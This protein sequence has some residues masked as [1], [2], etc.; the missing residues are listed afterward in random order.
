VRSLRLSLCFSS[1]AGSSSRVRDLRHERHERV[2]A[3]ASA[4]DRWCAVLALEAPQC[5]VDRIPLHVALHCC[6]VVD[7]SYGYCC[8]VYARCI[9]FPSG[10][11]P[12]Y[13]AVGTESGMG[14]MLLSCNGGGGDVGTVREPERSRE[15]WARSACACRCTLPTRR[16]RIRAPASAGDG[17]LLHLFYCLS[18]ILY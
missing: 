18:Y 17:G 9:S 11:I 1:I 7:S 15:G 16:S 13:A 8:W 6:A 10:G 3:R 2:C 12:V 4:G 14:M 5:G